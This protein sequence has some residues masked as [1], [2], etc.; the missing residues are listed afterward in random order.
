MDE[1]FENGKQNLS[2]ESLTLAFITNFFMQAGKWQWTGM[3]S[4]AWINHTGRV[5]VGSVYTVCSKAPWPVGVSTCS[6][7]QTRHFHL[8]LLSV[9]CSDVRDQLLSSIKLICYIGKINISFFVL[10][11]CRPILASCSA[12]FDHSGNMR[13]LYKMSAVVHQEHLAL[14]LAAFIPHI[15]L[16]GP[17]FCRPSSFCF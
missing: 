5:H 2:G 8:F 13:L 9:H 6:L 12:T 15:N 16:Y 3:M 7:S 1:V 10:K 17:G 11:P 14:T 4:H